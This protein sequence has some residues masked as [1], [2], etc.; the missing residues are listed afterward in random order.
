MSDQRSIRPEIPKSPGHKAE[1]AGP[2]AIVNAAGFAFQLAVE[3]AVIQT[4]GKHE[5]QVTSSEHSWRD[6]DNT[7]RFI[8]LVL[9]KDST[10][11]VVEC[12]RHRDAQWVFLVPESGRRSTEAVPRRHFRAQYLAN[13]T[14]ITGG[15]GAVLDLDDFQLDPKSWESSFCSVRGGSDRD[16]PMLDRICA[17]LTRSVDALLAQ[18]LKVSGRHDMHDIMLRDDTMWVGIPVIVTTAEL[19]IVRFDPNKVS[20]NAGEIDPTVATLERV[21]AIRYRKS[22]DAPQHPELDELSAVDA[23]TQRSVCVVAAEHLATWLDDFNLHAATYA[24]HK[25]QDS[26]QV[27]R[28]PSR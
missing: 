12:K 26:S 23:Y 21:H 8:D 19:W 2:L 5:W 7:P 22:F 10:H 15:I 3:E 9:T 18:Q 6:V 14:G 25:R 13:R 27:Y 11:L 4:S 28:R 17:E 16:Q 24:A 1:K 20:L